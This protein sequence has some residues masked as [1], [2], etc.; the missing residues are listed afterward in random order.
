MA[1]ETVTVT[2]STNSVTVTQSTNNA[3]V[4]ASNPRA[5]LGSGGT[6]QGSLDITQ[7]LDVDGVLETDAL[8]INGVSL[9]ET[10]QDVVGA[11]VGSNTETG[12][13]VAYDDSDG[14]LDFVVASQTDNNFT[15]ALKTKLDNLDANATDDQTAAEIRALVESATDSNVFT[16]ADHSKLDGIEASA[17][18]DQ[19]AAEIRALVESASDSNVFT[20]ADHTKL[21][22]IEASATAD[23]TASEIRTLVGSASDSNVFTDADH[24]KLDGIE[25]S[26]DV[27]LSAISAGTNI[28]I[29]AGGTI[30]ATDTNTQLTSEQVQ[31]IVGAMLTG[32]TETGIEVDYQDNDG[33]IDF[34]V[35]SQTDENFTT[36]DHTKLDGIEA[37]ATADQTAAEIRTLVESASDSNVFTDADHTK[38]N[39][40]EAGADVTPSWVPSSD[41]SYATQSYVTTQIGNVIDSAPAALDTLNEL[42][43]ALGDDA[44]FSTTIT[45]SIATKLPLAGGTMTGNLN[46]GEDVKLQL[47]GSNSLQL[48][49]DGSHSYID[50]TGTGDLILR[51][52]DQI[53]LFGYNNDHKMAVFNKGGDV[54]LFH[55]NSQKFATESG[56]ISVTGNIVVSGTVDGRDVATDGTKLDGIEASA[57]ADQ[58]A[59]EIRTLVDSASDSNVFTDSDHSKLD[60]IEASAT[61]DQT[62]SEIRTL[63]GSATDS[64]V[65]TDADHSKLDGIEA[66]ADVTLSA[67]SAG[68]NISISAGGTISATNSQLSNEQVQDIAGAMVDNNTESGITVEYDDDTGTLDFTVAS[69]TDNNFTNADHTKLDGIEA[70]ATADQTASEIRTLVG[71]ASDSNVFTDADHTKLDGI[72]AGATADQTAAEIKTLVDAASDSNVFTDADHSKLDGVETGAT[73]DQTAAEIRTLVGDATDSNV[74][75]DADHSKLDAIEASADVTDTANVVAA[76]TEGSNITIAADGTIAATDTNTTYSVGDG[77]LT[78]NNFTDADHSK[79]DGIEANATADQTAAEIR[80]LVGSASDSNVFT[81]ADHSKLDGIEASADVTLSAISAGSNITISAGGTISAT[82]TTYSVGDGGLTQNNFT[83]ADHSKLDGIEASADVTDATNVSAAGALMK[84]GGT[85]SGDLNLGDD[86]KLQLGG[87]N[88]LQI[89]HDESNSIIKDNGTGGLFL[90]ADAA[91]YIQSPTGE[92]KAKFTKDSGVELFFDNSKKFQTVTGGIDITG[93]ITV[94]GTVDGRDVAADG[95]KLDGIEAGATADQTAAEIRALV[96]SASDSNV[97]TDADHTKL[98]AIEAS[99]DVTPSWV[100]DSDPSYATQSYVTTQVNNL[101][102]SAPAALDT[103]N[104][105]AAAMGDD[106][107]FSTT[108]TNSIA[109]KLPLAGGTMTGNIVM[110]GSETVDGRDLS[111]D[112]SKLDGIEA[113]ATAD[114]T[115]AEI[116]TLV[117]SASDSNV[118]T[119]ADHSK[120][121]GIAA[122]ADVTLSAISAGTNISISAGG[123]ISATNT[124]YSVGDGGLTQNNFTDADHSKL[125]GIEAS[126][127]VTDATNVSAAGALMKSGGTMTGT[128]ITTRLEVEGGSSAILLKDTTDDDDHSITF[129]NH[130]GGDDYKIA[131]KDFTSASTGDGLFIG[132]ETTD[133][134]KLVTNDTIAL[135]LDSSQ[136]AAF[137]GNITVSGT[138]DGRD[139]ATDGTKL[140]GIEAS[141]TADQTA[142]EIRALVESASDS[143]VFTDA[144]HSKLNAIEASADVTDTAN[145]SSAGA[146]MKSGGTMT[147]NLVV[148][149]ASPTVKLTETDATSGFQVTDFSLSG[150]ALNLNT[151]NSSGTFVSTDYQISKNASGATIHKF[152]IANSEVAQVNSSGL[153]V[154]GAITVSSTVDGRD[155]ATD[156]S[157]LD[158]IESGATA[159]QTAAEIRTL[160]GNASDSN[161]FTDADH[162][163]LDGI[164]AS[165]TADQT[166]SEIRTLVDSASDSNVFTDADHSKLDG[167]EASATADQTASE[168]RTLV[169]SASDSNVFTDADHSKLDGIEASADVTLSAISAGSNITISAGGTISATNT[170]Y[171]VGD[172]GLTQN[173]FTNADHSKLDGIEAGATADQTASEIKTLVGSASDSNVF[174]DADHSKLDGIESGATADQTAAEIRTLVGS[175]SDSNVFTDADHS[176]LDGI[177]AGATADQDLS[178]YATQTYVT[179]QISNLVDSSPAALDTLNEL[180]AAIGDDANFSTTVTNSI[181]TKLPLAGG[182]LTGVL[183]LPDGAVGAPALSFANDADSGIYWD[184]S[185]S[186]IR[187]S[188][189][190]T[191]RAY[192]S[193]A[194]ILSTANLYTGNTGQFRNY[195]GVWKATTGLTGNGFQFNNSVDGTAMTLSSTGN[196]DVGNNITLGGT[197]DGRDVATDG[198]KLDGIESGATADQTAA[199]I[200]TLVGSASDS[201]VF[202]DADHS[203]LDGISANAD[204]TLSSISAGSNITISAGGTIAATNTTYSV[205]DGG[206]TQNNFTDADHSKLDG[207]EAS[208]T[209]D[210][211]ASEIRT[212]VESAS[213]SNVF[214]DADHT[215]LNA[216]EASA[217]VTDA[218]NVAAAGALMT[219]GGT[220]SGDLTFGDDDKLKLGTHGDLQLFHDNVR[221]RMFYTGANELQ[222][223]A[224]STGQL[225]F[226]DGS[227][228]YG[229]TAIT[230]VKDGAVS[231]RHDNSQKFVTSSSGIDITGNIVVSGTVDG[232]DLATDG[233]KLDGIE[234]GATADQTA[235]EIRTLVDSASD[236]NVF[237]DAD[238]SKLDGIEAS[239]TADQTAA[240]IRTLVESATDS[241]VFTDA[242]HSKLNGIAANADVTLS[243]IS[244]G[245]N[246]TISA[247]GTIAATNTTYSVGDGGLT[248]NN[249]TDADHSKLD[250]IESGATADQTASEI[251]TL[252]KT[253]DGSGS[254]L[255]ADTLD[256]ISSASFLRSDANDTTTGNLTISKNEPTLTL[257]DTNTGGGDFPQINFDTNNNQGVK[258]YHDEF[259]SNLPTSGY[260]LVLTGSDSNTQFPSTGTLSLCVLGEIYAGATSLGSLSRVLTT[261][262]EGSGNGLDADTLDGSHAS[263]FVTTSGDSTISGSLTVDDLTFNGS[264]ISDAGDFYIDAGGDITIDADGGDIIL[265]DGGT[266]VGTL[267]MNQNGG[268]FEVRSRVSDKDLVFKGNDG[269]SEITALTLDMSAGGNATFAGNIAL[270]GTVDGRDVA[271]DGSKL[272]GIASGADV[273]PSWVPSSDPSYATQSYVNTQVSNL[274]DSA[275]AALDTL[276][277]LAAAINDDASF[278]TTITNSI[279]TK[280][281]LAGGTLTGDLTLSYTYPRI[282]LTDTNHDSD[283]SLINNDGSFTIYDTTNAAHR[284][285][286]Q[287]NGNVGIGTTSN[288][289]GIS[290][291]L[292]SGALYVYSGDI[293]A[294][295][296]NSGYFASSRNLELQ[297]GSAAGVKLMSGSSTIVETNTSGASVTG[298]ITVSGTVDG[299]D[300]AT[301]GSKLDGIESGATADQTAA[302]IL[303]LI[304]TVDGSGSGLDADTLDGISSAS[305][306]RS[307]ASDTLTGDL[308][309]NGDLELQSGH[310]L[311][312]NNSDILLTDNQ[313]AAL[314]VKQGS[315][316]YLRFVTTNGSEEIQINQDTNI[317]GNL[318]LGGGN[319]VDGRDVSADGSKL[320]GIESGATADQTASEIRTL[321]GNASDSN[322]FTDADHSKLDGIEASATADQTASEILT[323]IKTVDGSGSGLDADT[324]DGVSSGSFLRSDAADTATELINLNGGL[325][326]H[327]GTSG[328]KFRIKRHTGSTDGDNIM[329]IHMDD[330]GAYFDIDN[331]DDADK[332]EFRLRYKTGGSFSEIFKVTPTAI[333]VA[334]TVDGRD[335]A[336]DGSKLD[337]IESGATADQSASEIRT[338]VESASDSNVFTDADHSKLNGIESGATADQTASEIRT[339][340]GSASDSNVF[341]DADHSKLDG[342]AASANNYSLPLA[343]S[344]TRGGVKIGYAENG[345]NYP[346]ELSSEKMYVNV[347]WTD[348]N[349]TY[350][351]GDGGLTQNNFTDADHDKLDGIAANANNYS[352]PSDISLN[353]LTVDT[354]KIDTD[355]TYGATYGTYGIGT[356]TLTNGHHRIFAKPT[357]HMYFA[358][359][360]G[361]GFRFRP[362]GGS[363]S[364]GVESCITSGGNLCVGATSGSSKLVVNGGVA[365]GASYTGSTAPTN[366]ILIQGNAGIGTS[367]VSG[368]YAL[369]VNGGLSAS[370]KSFVIDHPTKENKQLVHACLEGPENGVYLRGKSTSDTIP[371]PDY[372]EG[373]VDLDTMSVELTAIG[374][375]QCLF[376]ASMEANGDVVVGSNTDEPLN[377]YYVVYGERKDID[378]LTIEVDIEETEDDNESIADN[379]TEVDY[380]SVEYI[381]SL[382]NA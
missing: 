310:N 171:S 259:D 330:N 275:P 176:K 206:L 319:T 42:A 345:K 251:L 24:S 131:T 159:D 106:A 218:T 195:G 229:E 186:A 23:Q 207:I 7:N 232:R 108:I 189:D 245:S 151:R 316:L 317:A 127:D 327:S 295:N 2:Q 205:G 130:L 198:S 308:S 264:N 192:F 202:T 49:H 278:S 293:K 336:S 141:A 230:F 77:G 147:G 19:T 124:T 315:D 66:S 365:I 367:S 212:L 214:T 262:D 60:G 112:G 98:N 252:I 14:T 219:T 158:G 283:F 28:T 100:P 92:S 59:A 340:V 253:V 213:D 162:S 146:L 61:A 55:D 250:G 364:S 305:F 38:L 148:S 50:D 116:R 95:S 121:N 287:S 110:S 173:N 244:A 289:S 165:A 126:A 193:T 154:T 79:L 170:T 333:T 303:T 269:G 22:A 376:V 113:G 69:Q 136:D 164:E 48:Y 227:G 53:K 209:A 74:F 11:M 1:N 238:H 258:L 380:D 346:V 261:A 379:E 46:L 361:K 203:K 357:D 197:V 36:A 75:T 352:L 348:N 94:S 16:D 44:S 29:S 73:A 13:S 65:F 335:V 311:E 362:N 80:T 247:G 291:Q 373:L 183:K 89:Y 246:I 152:L 71:S 30:S 248:Q 105:L 337:G 360:T 280:L 363:N 208:A 271:S 332:G 282:N 191:Q 368:Y 8:T 67:I 155:L 37:N 3:S 21:N 344:S 128:L 56:G 215:K 281:P 204:V 377:Y 6:V 338:L 139:L 27:T 25:A 254:G 233:S 133:P 81:D 353:S 41:P 20:D 334:G 382:A 350:S 201:N 314:E 349:T 51:G 239:A 177:E 12:I 240:E 277:E 355:G 54:K 103:L 33:T 256:G 217:D 290:L 52:N 312:V 178:S 182:T 309:I 70:S 45:N 109:T 307:D 343:T 34:V 111:V 84:T 222:I 226:N 18:A 68:T 329:D 347:P 156:G 257:N 272:D 313:G 160:V 225:G 300:L 370:S 97:F 175:A 302:E 10:I 15:N 145:V 241:N 298:N 323:L 40:I 299:R 234:S 143:N 168:I 263:S 268:D 286:V 301:D 179:T 339:L 157:K 371:V 211:T 172:G 331:D 359:R 26:A 83:D 167:I 249:F 104:E 118:F 322:V 63:V 115:A 194:G 184:N 149:N 47:G 320:D 223:S 294:D 91:T 242:D 107:N 76:L 43:A 342:I 161:V 381:D 58:T 9:S 279:A 85:M 324:L 87:D 228:D 210:Q 235:A 326:V 267:S 32:N 341:T 221:G 102:D 88:D 123:T 181:A 82:N 185:N 196:L 150:G 96:E 57:T 351:V 200:R 378:K 304:K 101:V 62:A 187:F 117:E 142:A 137:A 358:A 236:S 366:G 174:T 255:D 273:T 188:I 122:N 163:K 153:D 265:K 231:I 114:Q 144:D 31:D 328:G 266:I 274:V 78:Q 190:G 374:S 288:N 99:A 199:E 17:T 35:A 285:T 5:G 369:E 132:S 375:N 125:D 354:N 39:A 140:D 296:I 372:W 237:T 180:A 129:R 306:L 297:G 224:G 4:V 321:V 292:Q 276:N 166:A 90:L 216:I 260:G 284:L 356:T 64:N 135:T 318:T 119:D 243:S 134:V 72:E 325:T 120:L 93:A 220:M 86:V 169:G 138:V 270:G